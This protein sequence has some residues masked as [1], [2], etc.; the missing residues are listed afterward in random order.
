MGAF[1]RNLFDTKFQ[2][3]VIVLPFTTPGG[4]VN[5]NTRDGRRTIGVQLSGRF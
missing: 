5:W 3:A 1:A 2:S 4:A